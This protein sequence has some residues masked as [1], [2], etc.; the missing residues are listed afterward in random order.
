MRA[1]SIVK[2]GIS[3]GPR[4]P[5]D[6]CGPGRTINRAFRAVQRRP[7][8]RVS[9]FAGQSTHFGSSPGTPSSLARENDNFGPS[10][11]PR[12][13]VWARSHV[14]SA[15]SSRLRPS[16]GLRAPVLTSNR[17]FCTVR[18]FPPAR[19][20]PFAR[21]FAILSVRE[22]PGARVGPVAPQIGEFAPTEGSRR[23]VWA[24]SS[25]KSA[26]S[27][28]QGLPELR[29]SAFARQIVH[30][31]PL[32]APG[33]SCEPIRTSNRPFRAGTGS[34]SLEWARATVKLAISRR[35]G[36]PE[37]RAGPFARQISHFE[38]PRAPGGSCGPV[39][40]SNR[41]FRGVRMPPKAR[42]GPFASQIPAIAGHRGLPEARAG[43]LARQV[44]D[45]GPSE[46][47]D[48]PRGPVRTSN[49]PI[50]DRRFLPA[51][52]VGPLAGQ[53]C[54]FRAVRGSPWPVCARSHAK[55]VNFGPLGAPGDPCGPTRT[56]N[57][58]FSS[59]QGLP[60]TRVGPFAH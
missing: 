43:P 59:R 35:Q 20:T 2:S 52:R 56:S 7:A 12:R 51:T 44:S 28:R 32:K 57:L 46:V 18:G 45:F 38:L 29:V 39:R 36:L 13:F 27:G 49:P 24:R 11:G 30:F 42:V 14:K 31:E 53:I 16:A 25:A 50:S 37:T 1:A 3:S 40:S 5:G 34:R 15:I 48:D 58:S 22:L 9:S 55:S 19:A 41:R 54:H 23:L 33:S 26:I 21:L 10:E 60:V 17:R 47:P 4:L 6:P 8:A